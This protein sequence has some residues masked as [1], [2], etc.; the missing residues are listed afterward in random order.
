[1]TTVMKSLIRRKMRYS[2][3]RAA[4]VLHGQRQVA[5]GQTEPPAYMLIE[6]AAVNGR[7]GAR[8]FFSDAIK[9]I[10]KYKYNS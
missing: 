3:I 10:V 4:R 1:M 9:N 5:R 7:C 2:E 8:R 6:F